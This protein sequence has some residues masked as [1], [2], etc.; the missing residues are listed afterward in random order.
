MALVERVHKDLTAA[1]K[2]KHPLR[3]SVLRMM[4]SALQLK[5]S[6][7]GEAVTEESAQAVLRTLLKQRREAAQV[8]REAGR[9]DLADRELAEASIIESYLPEPASEAEMEAAVSEAISETGASK[10]ADLG[11]V[12]KAAMARLAGKTVDGKRLSGIARGKLGA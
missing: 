9:G 7:S 12:M 6:E 3:L 1:M 8:F 2:E 4:K 5:Q 11:K 10:A